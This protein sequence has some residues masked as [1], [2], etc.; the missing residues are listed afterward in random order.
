MGCALED[1]AVFGM[2][3]EDGGGGEL[4]VFTVDH[5]HS[6]VKRWR[7]GAEVRTEERYKTGLGVISVHIHDASGLCHKSSGFGMRRVRYGE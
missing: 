7:V 1:H 5:I 3:G 2:P 4:I 6:V